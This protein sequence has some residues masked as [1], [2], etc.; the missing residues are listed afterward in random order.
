MDHFGALAHPWAFALMGT[1]RAQSTYATYLAAALESGAI[2]R[3]PDDASDDDAAP[4]IDAFRELLQHES[5]ALFFRTHP[6]RRVNEDMSRTL[7]SLA[8]HSRDE[9]MYMASNPA[10][11]E[12]RTRLPDLTYKA[13]S[14]AADPPFA[15][16]GPEDT[17]ALAL[18]RWFKES[19]MTWV[20][21]IKCPV[22]RGPT[23]FVRTDTIDHRRSEV[24]WCQDPS[25]AV[26]RRFDRHTSVNVLLH[27]REGRCGEW[28]QLFYVFLLAAGLDA[29]Y[30]WNSEDHVWT[31]YWS[32]A[33][34]H[35]VHVDSCE[36]I[37]NR[38]LL[39]ARGW[40][41]KQAFCLAYGPYGA[42]DVTRAYVDDWGAC[43]MRRAARGWSERDLR[44]ELLTETVRCRLKLS[45]D[46]RAELEERDRLQKAWI[47]DE[48]ARLRE[49]DMQQ[50]GGR[51]SGP[52][53]WRAR[54]DELGAVADVR[55]EH[56]VVRSLVDVDRLELYGHAERREDAITL[57][58]GPSQTAAVF[59]AT[60]ISQCTSWRMQLE[61]RLTAPPGC[62]EADGM[63]V[64][65]SPER[66]LGL[67]GFGLGYTG[68][69]GK[70]DFAIEIDTYHTQDHA[71]DPP[72]PHVSVHSPPHAHHRHSIA[73]AGREQ[74]PCLTDGWPYTLDVFF[75]S[76]DRSLKAFL[77][78]A[79]KDGGSKE[80]HLFDARIPEGEN[81][82]WYA[83]V[84][85]SCG[86][87][88]LT[89]DVLGWTMDE[90]E[91]GQ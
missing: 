79:A 5:V 4:L 21:P 90:V 51:I 24:H 29:R 34:G 58:S 36:A 57:T 78:Y 12:L 20:D 61:F 52:A 10:S 41:K 25:C 28:A 2:A 59:S 83:G 87:L 3:I 8:R 26:E 35:W 44:L 81:K 60:P 65:L 7:R 46:Q 42:E 91:H 70:G 66:K 67:G 39:Y 11:Y 54:R 47:N 74:L 1:T 50:L 18:A 33:L 45:R 77:S 76:S 22:C 43:W 48:T 13:R 85:A 40:G 71:D 49:A 89:Q 53:E 75:K 88:W 56:K 55:P 6:R 23:S 17:R 30:V 16:F 14:I 86:G 38:P 15:P 37:S 68:L 80:I 72:T 82:D 9:A 62:G 84:T 19:F 69:G 32:P 64:V 31:E 63:A 27:T 73:L